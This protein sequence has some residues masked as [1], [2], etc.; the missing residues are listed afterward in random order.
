M[1]R[2]HDPHWTN[3]M[4]IRL[5]F[6][7]TMSDFIG[8]KRGITRRE[9]DEIIPRALEIADNIEA[10]R[11]AGELGFYQLP[12]DLEAADVVSQMASPLREECDD[13]VVLGIG[14]SALGGIA[15][16]HS[17]CRPLHNLFSKTDRCGM[18]R[19]FFLDNID[20]HTFKGILDLIH[21]ERTV[22]NVVTKS[23]STAETFQQCHY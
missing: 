7:N 1:E 18:P 8:E 6:D 19:V 11:K 15:L 21:P 12:Y 23:G 5:D 16:F 17:L 3:K 14:G 9:I 10:K 2:W 13:F 20:P 4:T 22:F